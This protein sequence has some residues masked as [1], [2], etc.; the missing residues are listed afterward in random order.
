[1]LYTVINSISN[2]LGW[3]QRPCVHT[4]VGPVIMQIGSKIHVGINDRVRLQFKVFINIVEHGHSIMMNDEDVVNILQ[5]VGLV[6]I[7]VNVNF[8]LVPHVRVGWARVVPRV[9]HTVSQVLAES[10]SSTLEDTDSTNND[11]FLTIVSTP[12]VSKDGPDLF[13]NGRSHVGINNIT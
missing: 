7:T 9:T 4:I 5:D 2:V 11:V 12:F 3:Y 10:R 13:G 6:Y 1:M 8:R